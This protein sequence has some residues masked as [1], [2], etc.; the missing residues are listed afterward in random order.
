MTKD[1]K[2]QESRA[3]QRMLLCAIETIQFIAG[4]GDVARDLDRDRRILSKLCPVEVDK[5]SREITDILFN[6]IE[7]LTDNEGVQV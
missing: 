7:R 1:S 6:E 3:E 5:V 4:K 2:G